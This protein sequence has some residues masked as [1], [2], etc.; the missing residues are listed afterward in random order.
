MKKLAAFS[1]LL[2]APAFAQSHAHHERSQTPSTAAYMQAAEA[3]HS[4]MDIEYTGDA[5]VDFMRGMIPHHEAAVAMAKIALEHGQDPEV[6][7]LA[8]QVIAAQE[9]EIALMQDWL[10]RHEQ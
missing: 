3:M 2:A 5:D 7:N 8:Q 9:A 1:I 10:S 6:R 4:G